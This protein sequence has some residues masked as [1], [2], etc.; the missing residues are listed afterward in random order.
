[1]DLSPITTVTSSAA[2]AERVPIQTL[3]QNDFLKLLVTQMTSQDPLN[4][5]KDT[6]FIAQMAQFSVLEQSKTMQADMAQL[7][8]Q[9]QLAQASAMIGQ[10]VQL[11]LAPDVTSRGIVAA[12]Q[13]DGSTPKLIV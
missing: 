2:A 6:E 4:P 11:E 5:Q 10:T 9:Q 7:C 3:G 1:M 13:I 8:T 12:V